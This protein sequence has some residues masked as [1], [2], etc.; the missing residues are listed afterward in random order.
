MCRK[1]RD[2][3]IIATYEN[4]MKFGQSVQST[5]SAKRSSSLFVSQVSTEHQLL[6]T[7]HISQ[8]DQLPLASS[9]P[10]E[11]KFEPIPPTPQ[12]QLPASSQPQVNDDLRV[13]P[14]TPADQLPAQP[15]VISDPRVIASTPDDLPEPSSPIRCENKTHSAAATGDLSL[16]EVEGDAS[17]DLGMLG[18]E[19]QWHQHGSLIG[20]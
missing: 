15:Q 8:A 10:Q 1:L 12:D 14:S 5:T 3:H 20:M 13:I 4:L 17:N 9:Q 11:A 7:S 16:H 18:T 6:L 19:V 2:I